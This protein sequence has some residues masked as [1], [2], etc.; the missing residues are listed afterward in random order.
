M[1]FVAV[2]GDAE[3][4]ILSLGCRLIDMVGGLGK[5]YIVWQ[6]IFDNGVKVCCL[7]LLAVNHRLH[8][9]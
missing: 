7:C 8:D 1:C 6:E 4:L 2:H 5:S 9:A 3:L